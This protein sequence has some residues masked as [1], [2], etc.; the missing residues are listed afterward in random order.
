[1]D[2]LGNILVSISKEGL[3]LDNGTK[4]IG[5]GGILSTLQFGNNELQNLGYEGDPFST[6][7][8]TIDIPFYIPQNFQILEA[9]LLLQHTSAK[10]MYTSDGGTVNHTIW[11][12]CR[13]I[14]LYKDTPATDFYK[15]V[16]IASE[17]FFDTELLQEEIANAFGANGF[18]AS[19]PASSNNKTERVTSINIADFLEVGQNSVLQIRSSNPIPS[20][21]GDIYDSYDSDILSQTGYARAL[22]IVTGYIK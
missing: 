2:A 1:M 5:N 17:G 8:I 19:N 21:D 11:G 22:L 12:Y 18:T 16:Q 14:K 7:Y 20:F 6:G 13:N 3:V 4:L 10:Y 15:T 9:K